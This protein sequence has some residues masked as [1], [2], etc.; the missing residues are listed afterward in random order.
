MESLPALISLTTCL[1]DPELSQMRICA[2][3]IYLEI[4]SGCQ[5]EKLWNHWIDL[6]CFCNKIGATEQIHLVCDLIISEG[7]HQCHISVEVLLQ[8]S[9]LQQNSDQTA[10]DIFY[11]AREK[12]IRAQIKLLKSTKSGKGLMRSVF[13]ERSDPVLAFLTQS[14]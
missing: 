3:E 9:Q 11:C 1:E 6:L 13:W 12:E 7:S 5:K 14:N 8:I 10:R 4:V 2:I